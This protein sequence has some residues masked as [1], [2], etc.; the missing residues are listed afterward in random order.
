MEGEG[1]MLKYI[2][3]KRNEGL[4]LIKKMTKNK[5]RRKLKMKW[6]SIDI[7]YENHAKKKGIGCGQRHRTKRLG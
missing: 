3:C 6:N 1:G 2:N 7:R 4:K 5:T